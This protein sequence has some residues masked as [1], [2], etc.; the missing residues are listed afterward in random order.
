MRPLAS[1]QSLYLVRMLVNFFSPQVK[2]LLAVGKAYRAK[3]R[4]RRSEL[5]C[6][7]TSAAFS[8]FAFFFLR[9]FNTVGFF[10][11][12]P[13]FRVPAREQES[14]VPHITLQVLWADTRISSM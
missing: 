14:S 13:L 1:Y 2:A 3:L 10:T 7:R 11:L 9:W 8:A 6:R 12:Q 5:F 4:F